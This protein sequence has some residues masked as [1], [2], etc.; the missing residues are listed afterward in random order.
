MSFASASR[1]SSM[2]WWAWCR[3]AARSYAV[4]AAHCS[5]AAAADSTATRTSSTP[6]SATES[7]TSPV[8]GFLDSNVRPEAA[9]RHSPLMYS[10]V[11]P[12]R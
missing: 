11:R 10:I 5:N 3:N 7:M 12:Y 8:A 6:A 4:R 9:V 2:S 1:R